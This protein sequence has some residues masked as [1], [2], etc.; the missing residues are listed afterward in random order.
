MSIPGTLDQTPPIYLCTAMQALQGRTHVNQIGATK[1]PGHVSF[2]RVA[3]VAHLAV[4]RGV[5]HRIKEETLG[6]LDVY[7]Q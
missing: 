1:S 5:Y 2:V 7:Y 3:C 4:L 6:A